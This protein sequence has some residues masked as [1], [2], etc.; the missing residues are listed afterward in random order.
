VRRFTVVL[1]TRNRAMLHL[2]ERT[3]AVRI[4]ACYG[5]T[6]E[7][8]V[9]LPLDTGAPQQALRAAAAGKVHT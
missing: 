3:G 8:V 2:F 1:L 7:L 9:E 4:T 6:L 5:D